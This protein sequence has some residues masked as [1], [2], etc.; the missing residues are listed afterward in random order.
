M[1]KCKGSDRSKAGCRDLWCYVISPRLQVI[2]IARLQG[3]SRRLRRILLGTPRVYEWHQRVVEFSPL[4][5][6]QKAAY[7]GDS[8]LVALFVSLMENDETAA[9]T[10][11]EFKQAIIYYAARG[12]H[13]DIALH[14]LEQPG[15]LLQH[16]YWGLIL[17]G[18]ARGGHWDIVNVAIAMNVEDYMI[19]NALKSAAKG[20]HR[21]LVDF[22]IE[23][24]ANNWLSA[25]YGA[26]RGGHRDLVEMFLP[27]P[28]IEQPFFTPPSRWLL[29]SAAQSGKCD[30]VKLVRTTFFVDVTPIIVWDHILAGAARGGHENI[31]LLALFNGARDLNAALRHAARGG[32]YAL[33]KRFI[34]LLAANDLNVDFQSAF[35]QA[36]KGGYI[37]FN[38]LKEKQIQADF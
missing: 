11:C 26:A 13:F 25:L 4:K 24:G 14:W 7:Q 36:R 8:G 5:C 6:L 35:Q 23:R 33:V 34:E 2:D 21:D 16:W 28:A 17:K 31:V 27:L 37:G 9:M 1:I 3:V 12:G 19:E 30:I 15:G 29:Y 20:G 10:M 18:A 32:H 38:F 22:F